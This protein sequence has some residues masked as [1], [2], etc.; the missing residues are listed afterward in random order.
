MTIARSV[1]RSGAL[2]LALVILAIGSGTEAQGVT[3]DQYRAAETP[4]DGFVVTRPRTMGHLDVSAT[5]HLEYALSPLRA[6]ASGTGATLVEHELVGQVG[7][8]LGI[9]DRFVF[10]LRAP[11]VLFMPG[12]APGAGAPGG[13]D[14]GAS[15]ASPGDLA[16]T[17]R[18]Q[19]VG[20]EGDTFALA[21]QTEATI[22]LAEA[23]SAAQ[24]LA[25]ES[26]VSF[27]PELA[28]ELRF[29]PVR[30]TAN[31]GARFRE[32]AVYV[33]LGVRNELTWALA[34]GVDIVPGVLDATIEGFGATPFDRFANAPSSPVE[35]LGG[36]RV[37]PVPQLYLGLAGGGGLG[38]G[39]GAPVF[40]GVFTI[41]YADLDHPAPVAPVEEVVETEIVAVTEEV[42]ETEAELHPEL[43]EDLAI[44]PPPPDVSHV[45]PPEPGDYGQLDRDGDRI[46]DAE[47]ACVL[48]AE[49]YDEIV[50]SDGCPEEDADADTVA[51]VLDVCPTT[52]GVVTDDPTTTGCP[53]RAHLDARGAIVITDR[54]E[55]ATGSDRIL[56][57]SEPVLGDVL[58]ILLSAEDVAR[59]RI[60]GHTDDQGSDRR[61]IRLSRARA[62]SV[63]A[64]LVERGVPAERLEAWG[65]GEGH[66]L[67]EGRGRAAR[68]TNRRVEF[69]VVD[70]MSPGLVLRERCVEGAP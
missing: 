21:L 54:V 70:P 64:W 24:D 12:A 46:V 8:A 40:R 58:A 16:V 44:E 52:V 61:N 13:R 68:Q 10:A 5:L 3:L 15:G 31:L 62:A 17:F 2:F 60:E 57:T 29:A 69:F 18:A 28:A 35:L 1:A 30:I 11:I 9:L 55:F 38:D 39:Y 27:T 43:A 53:A 59:V 66:P 36:V 25:G 47:D 34:V 63:V 19:L 48:D 20:E 22:P 41:G 56:P 14:P 45:P 7:A 65:C 49:D 26:G 32:P 37:R 4:R 67:V 42:V 23:I 33:N 51:D 50:D 6:S